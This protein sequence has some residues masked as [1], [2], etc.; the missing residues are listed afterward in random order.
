MEK[1]REVQEKLNEISNLVRT[2][3]SVTNISTA[4]SAVRTKINTSLTELDSLYSELNEE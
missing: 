2:L 4:W 3:E 1:I